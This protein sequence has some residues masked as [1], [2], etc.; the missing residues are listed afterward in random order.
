MASEQDVKKYLA[1]WF[2]AGKCVAL[3]GGKESYCPK[4][5]LQG[6]RYSKEFEDCWNHLL[7]P[8][9]GDCYLEGTTQTINQLLSPIWDISPCARC[10]MPIPML[11]LG[12]PPTGCPCSDLPNW[13]ND[14]IPQPRSPVS[15]PDHLVQI[16]DRL[17]R[18]RMEQ[19]YSNSSSLNGNSKQD[20]P[21]KRSP[22]SNQDESD[23]KQMRDRL[24]RENR[25]I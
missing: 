15:T 16:R 19:S 18:Q 17:S 1:Y 20:I 6:D 4:T 22:I 3:K 5:V 13:P 21:E 14:E 12:V 8:A 24:F 2:Q 10:D 23:M 7:D 11:V 25:Y 9:S